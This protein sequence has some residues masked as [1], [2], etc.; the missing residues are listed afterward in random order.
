M[1]ALRIP[2]STAHTSVTG[3]C[4][5]NSVFIRH[6]ASTPLYHI[7]LLD[8]IRPSLIASLRLTVLASHDHLCFGASF[9]PPLSTHHYPS[10]TSSNPT[11]HRA[12]VAL[13]CFVI[14]DSRPTTTP[15]VLLHSLDNVIVTSHEALRSACARIF[16]YHYLSGR[17]SAARGRL[18]SK[19]QALASC[20]ESRA[21]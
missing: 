16:H 7:P 17:G 15:R 12:H 2:Q 19:S 20:C 4:K 10:P 21:R 11:L 3:V 13:S 5:T 18:H 6:C 9:S 14:S 8:S 1:F